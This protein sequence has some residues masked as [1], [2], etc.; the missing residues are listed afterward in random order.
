MKTAHWDDHRDPKE[1]LQQ[2][3]RRARQTG[4]L[5]VHFA[6]VGGHGALHWRDLEPWTRS[7]AVTVA[8]LG[9]SI[10]SP[11]LDVAMCCDLLCVR[12]TARLK[13]SDGPSPPAP[14]VIW[15][16]GLRGRRAL[17]RGLLELAEI[18]AS[19]CRSLGLADEI[20]ADDAE[21]P[22]PT[23][24]SVAALTAARDLVRSAASGGPGLALELASFRL[25]FAA[26][27]PT[28]G[29]QAFL[30]KRDPVFDE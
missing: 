15:G 24:A 16:L 21:L 20:L 5:A 8:D 1:Q 23:A 6:S 29:A 10:S 17:A 4:I 9:G 27:D 25:L 19:E 30:A 13:L 7:R 11:A 28:E 14:G 12:R 3:V 2:L 22:I 26:G 18:D